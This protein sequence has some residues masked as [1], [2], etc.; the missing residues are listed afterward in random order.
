VGRRNFIAVPIVLKNFLFSTIK[1]YSCSKN[2]LLK[3]G[4]KDA[5]KDLSNIE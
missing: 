5:G 3:I 2:C 4:L 1:E